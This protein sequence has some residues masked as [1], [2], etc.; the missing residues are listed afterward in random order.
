MNA[1]VW[2]LRLSAP[3]LWWVCAGIWNRIRVFLWICKWRSRRVI[4]III[5]IGGTGRWLGSNRR[6]RLLVRKAFIGRRR[7]CF[8]GT[9]S[10][11]TRTRRSLR[12]RFRV[13]RIKFRCDN[14][15]MFLLRWEILQIYIFRFECECGWVSDMFF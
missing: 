3:E 13:W 15:L 10:Q 4:I 11:R 9:R 7:L 5:P 1:F 14:F 8:D 6:S 12:L 2:N